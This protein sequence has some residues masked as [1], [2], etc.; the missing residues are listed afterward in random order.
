MAASSLGRGL[1]YG[2]AT[3]TRSQQTTQSLVPVHLSEEHQS[4][5]LWVVS[6]RRVESMRTI[7]PQGLSVCKTRWFLV[8]GV[9]GARSDSESVI[10]TLYTISKG[11]RAILPRSG[12]RYRSC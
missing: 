12:G 8:L 9:Y 1:R 5:E 7:R 6:V 11:I 2:P 4:I 3:G 10:I